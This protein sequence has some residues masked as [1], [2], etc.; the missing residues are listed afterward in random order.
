MSLTQ[1]LKSFRY[2]FRGFGHLWRSEQNFR[3]QVLAGA[4]ALAAAWILP[5]L[6][7]QRITIVLLVAMVLVLEIINSVI[8]RLADVLKSRIHPSVRDMKDMMATA[9]LLASFV[10]LLIGGIIL[11]PYLVQLWME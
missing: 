3:L 10:A 6:V 9:V 8:E 7:W 5:L 1:L 4:L 2:A 11:Y